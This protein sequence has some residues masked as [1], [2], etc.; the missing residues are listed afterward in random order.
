MSYRCTCCGKEHPGL[1]DLTFEKPD[2][3]WGVP[4]NERNQRIGSTTD[5]CI[6][7]DEDYFIRGLIDIPILEYRNHFAF[8]VWV[9]QKRENFETYV[10][11]FDTDRIGP[12]FGWLCN[13][14]RYY[15][16]DT[17]FLKT[18]VHFRGEG[19]RPRF[20]LQ[21]SDHPLAIAQH[22]GMTLG[23]AWEIVHFYAGPS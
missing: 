19:S 5:T 2:P 14:I 4:E 8:G 23:K 20:E 10:N 6:I 3:W 11:N 16:R 21:P 9:S 15:E 1:P 22:D 18:T 13:R 7:D 17:L 12:Y